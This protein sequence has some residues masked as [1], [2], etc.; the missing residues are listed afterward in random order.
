MQ[1]E[2]P[3]APED[4][5]VPIPSQL[6]AVSTLAGLYIL[7]KVIQNGAKTF[8]GTVEPDKEEACL[9]MLKTFRAMQAP[10]VH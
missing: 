4:P 9:N 8:K 5:V 6:L 1:N 2:D 7:E 10:R 3:V